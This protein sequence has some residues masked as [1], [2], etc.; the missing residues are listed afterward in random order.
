MKRTLSVNFNDR[1]VGTL[2]QDE[3]G[4]IFFEYKSDWLSDPLAIPLSQSLPLREGEFKKKECIGFF[5][6][7]L[8]EELNREIIAKNLGLSTRNDFILLEHLGG[9]C[10]GL[11]S[12]EI[13]QD[14]AAPTK[15]NKP[16]Y[17]LLDEDEL[18]KVLKS[19]PIKPL[20]AGSEGVR[21]SL[22][23][24]QDKVVLHYQKGQFSIPCYGAP[25]THILKPESSRFAGTVANEAYCMRLA[26]S[27]G[28]RVA[29]VETLIVKDINLLN[30]MRYDRILEQKGLITRLH[31]EDFCQALGIISE[32]KYQKEGGPSLVDCFNLVRKATTEPALDLKRLL[33]A[34]IFNVIIGNN[35]AHGKNFSIVYSNGKVK[36]APLYDLLCTAFYPEVSVNMAMKIGKAKTFDELFPSDFHAFAIEAGLAPKLVVRRVVELAKIAQKEIE[37]LPVTENIPDMVNLIRMRIET[38]LNRFMTK[39]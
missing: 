21:I 24:A 32:K 14:S 16:S 5:G 39:L 1:R 12:F 9:E 17:K 3:Y 8:P 38:L 20:L 29:K 30:V 4:A 28:L 2:R 11:V 36:L 10:A 18:Y 15:P 7:I 35:D 22:A 19:L 31:Q 23:G 34:V 33:D 27:M 37:R 25:S 13:E 26:D 6:G